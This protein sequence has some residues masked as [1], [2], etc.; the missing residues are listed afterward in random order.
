MKLPDSF[1]D[2]LL[3]HARQAEALPVPEGAP[4]GFATRVLAQWREMEQRDWMLWLLPR[5]VSLAA[6]CVLALLAVD[7]LMAPTG[8]EHELAGLLMSSALEGQP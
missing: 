3:R 5:A 7:G 4:S 8:E 2:R 6:V 1:I